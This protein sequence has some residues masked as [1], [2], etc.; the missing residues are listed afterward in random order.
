MHKPDCHDAMALLIQEIRRQIPFHLPETTLCAGD[1]RGCSKKMLE[2]LDSETSYWE[3][4]LTQ[5]MPTLR[6]IRNLQVLAQRT[7]KILKRNKLL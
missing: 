5:Q 7:H 2:M 6:D 3:S 1:C 4:M